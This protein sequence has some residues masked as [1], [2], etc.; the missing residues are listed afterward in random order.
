MQSV[1]PKFSNTTKAKEILGLGEFVPA[2]CL[3][4]AADMLT[5]GACF[6]WETETLLEELEELDCLPPEKARDRMLAGIA[7]LANPAFLWDA[8]AFMAVAQT[9]SGNLAVP[10]IWEPLS[11]AAVAYS[12]Q[13]LDSLYSYYNNTKKLR[14]LYNE[15]PKIYIAGCCFNS[16]FGELPKDLALCAEQFERFFDKPMDPG[17]V[18]TNP[19]QERK[20]IEVEAYI[21]LMTKLRART[22]SELK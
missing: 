16:G 19:V 7:S 8:G 9:F 15:D 1:A 22:I 11:P 4:I 3:V 12:I 17:E 21:T 10:E 6:V 18:L 14:P 2:T 20:H 5:S 13:E